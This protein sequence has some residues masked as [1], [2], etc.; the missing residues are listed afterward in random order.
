MYI[1]LNIQYFMFELHDN[2]SLDINVIKSS[3][4]TKLAISN[5]VIYGLNADPVVVTLDGKTVSSI[6]TLYSNSS[7]FSLEFQEF[8]TEVDIELE[9]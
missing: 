1:I 5:V 7:E 4:S 6:V 2:C 3:C 8:G 9:V